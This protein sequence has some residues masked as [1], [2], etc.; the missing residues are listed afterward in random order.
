MHKHNVE[1]ISVFISMIMMTYICQRI[2][3]NQSKISF[4]FSKI[5]MGLPRQRKV[6]RLKYIS[7]SNVVDENDCF[8]L[9]RTYIPL[10]IYQVT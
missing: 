2:K 6:G 4:I 8:N 10:L 5:N 9:L 3:Q 1:S 7:K